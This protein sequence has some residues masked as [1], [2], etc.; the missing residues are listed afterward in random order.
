MSGIFF[1]YQPGRISAR[2]QHGSGFDTIVLRIRMNGAI[3]TTTPCDDQFPK[4][5][6]VNHVARAKD[7]SVNMT[8]VW[9][10]F[11]DFIRFLEAIVIQV[12]ECS[13][14]WDAEGPSGKMMWERRFV[15]ENGFLTVEWYSRSAKFKY[16]MMLDTKQTVRMLYT[17][18][19]RFIESPEYDPIRYEELKAGEAFRLVLT[20]DTESNIENLVEKLVELDVRSAERLI[21]SLCQ[22]IHQR[23]CDKPWVRYSLQHYV[24]LSKEAIVEEREWNTWLPADWDIKDKVQRRTE[25]I[26]GVFNVGPPNWYG[27]NLRLLRSPL[28]EV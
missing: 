28:I 20:K 27:A 10:P 11:A 26:E 22:I 1:N 14:D 21:F 9:C 13:F 17:A 19:R 15:N 3:V 5:N 7:F 2:F 18:F 23:M 24:L 12:K 25:I 16:R 6:P 4:G 8:S